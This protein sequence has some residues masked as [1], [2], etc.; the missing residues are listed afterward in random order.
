MKENKDIIT[1]H[2]QKYYLYIT[3]FYQNVNLIKKNQN[4]KEIS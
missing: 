2:I 1:K 3:F 4:G